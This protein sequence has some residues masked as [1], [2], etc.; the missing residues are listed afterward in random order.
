MGNVH[1]KGKASGLSSFQKKKLKYDFYTFFGKK[2][3]VS[4]F[5]SESQ[6]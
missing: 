2:G 4:L 5:R 3:I 1:Q 6:R